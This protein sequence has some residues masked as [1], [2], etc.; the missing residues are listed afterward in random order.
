MT[1]FQIV[2]QSISQLLQAPLFRLG[3]T[4]ISAGF[5][6][7]LLLYT[8][9]VYGG[10]QVIKGFL[11]DR[12]LAKL[13]IDEG[14]RGTIAGIISYS[15]GC[16]V[17][18]MLLQSAGLNLNSLAVP[19]GALGVGVGLGLQNITKNVV[20]GLNL[21]L[22]RK[23]RV[24]DF[25][26]FDGLT[27]HVVEIA[28]RSAVIR[29]LDGAHVIVPNSDLVEKRVINWH[30]NS[31]EARLHLRVSVAYNSDPLVVT[32][33]LL[34]AAYS[35]PMVLEEPAPTVILL[36]TGDNSLDFDLR[37]WVKGYEREFDV[38]HALNCAIEYKFHQRGIEMPFPQRDLWLRNPEVLFPLSRR[39]A[40]DPTVA[41]AQ[42]ALQRER[43]VPIDPNLPLLTEALRR[44]SYFSHLSD[45]DLRRIV[46]CGYR[47]RLKTGEILFCEGDP[48][49]G[50]YIVLSGS[51]KVFVAKLDKH[52]TDLGAGEFL[53]ELALMLGIPRTA[54]VRANEETLLFAINQRGFTQL[55]QRHPP[56]A[57]A[58][59]QELSA[60]QEE[61][62]DRQSELRALGLIADDEDDTN[63][64]QWVR[65]RIERLFGLVLL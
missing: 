33:V 28:L 20:G 39:A 34:D 2:W 62:R 29:T 58:I 3:E 36:S 50:F 25:I 17:L 55:F 54:T 5:L 11:Q 59:V 46:E 35:E 63:P 26:E 49:N 9:L 53:G 16:L 64:V 56:I 15:V 38:R 7:Q 31:L 57:S 37:V 4:V 65:K 18:V 45:L 60:R 41:P 40:I 43:V 1:W 13:R 61:L 47:Q 12:L 14:N 10:A 32:E 8:I 51:V 6:L 52:L 22:E 27:G 44:V 24:G 23:L 48:G 30:Y 19:A 42:P 21:L